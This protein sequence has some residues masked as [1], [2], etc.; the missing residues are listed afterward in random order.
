MGPSLSTSNH[1]KEQTISSGVCRDV[2]LRKDHARGTKWRHCLCCGAS[3]QGEIGALNHQL[4]SDYWQK[5]S[6]EVFWHQT[7]GYKDVPN[8]H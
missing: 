3:H 5:S 8:G 4:E 2:R 1:T 6:K 7:I